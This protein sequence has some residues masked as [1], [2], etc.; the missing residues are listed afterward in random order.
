MVNIPDNRGLIFNFV[1]SVE[2]NSPAKVPSKKAIKVLNIGFIPKEINLANTKAPKGKVPS[3]DKS[4]I[5]SSL[6]VIY[7]P[8][9]NIAKIKP[10]SR[11]VI[12]NVIL[13]HPSV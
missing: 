3:T 9:A 7:T 11:E 1:N 8:I 6:Y 10:C 4:E 12:N 2:V 13:S 5:F